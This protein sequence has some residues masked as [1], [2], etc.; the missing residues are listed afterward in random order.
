MDVNRCCTYHNLEGTSVIS[1]SY[2]Y[3]FGTRLPILMCKDLCQYCY[4]VYNYKFTMQIFEI[5]PKY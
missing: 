5:Y 2:I 1:I 4:F 3:C